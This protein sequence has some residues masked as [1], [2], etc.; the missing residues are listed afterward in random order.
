M[1]W[2]LSPIFCLLLFASCEDEKI[3]IYNQVHG[4]WEWVSSSG[5]IA[6]ITLTPESTGDSK[7]I[8]FETSGTY[9]KFINDTLQY[10]TKY[11]IS[12]G[13]SIFSSSQYPIIHF[14]EEELDQAIFQVKDDTL[15]LGGNC[16]DCFFH[17]F[18]RPNSISK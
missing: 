8:I 6:G 11:S 4:N 2:I 14:K 12:E 9:R 10:T 3:D 17:T 1:K 18:I 16:F 15:K 5:G 7:L 13:E